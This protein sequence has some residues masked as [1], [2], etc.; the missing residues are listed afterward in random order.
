MTRANLCLLGAGRWGRRY[1]E[2]IGAMPGLQLAALASR[3]P[4]SEHL[5]GSG[6][7][8]FP[9]WRDAIA[10]PGID[11]VIIATPPALHAEMAIAT[12]ERG[13]PVLVE[14]PLTLSPDQA[15]A[16][17][18]AANRTQVAAMVGHIHLHNAGYLE[19]KRQRH[20]VGDLQQIR[21]AAGNRGPFRP[22]V[23]PLWDWAPHDLS[24]CLD[25][26]GAVPR[27]VS[28]RRSAQKWHDGGEGANYCLDLEF[29]HGVTAD[30]RVGNLMPEKTRWLELAGT[31]GTLR[32]DDVA[33]MLE[34]RNDA[35]VRLLPF[36]GEKPLARQLQMFAAAISGTVL[37][38]FG[39]AEGCAVVELLDSCQTLCDQG[40]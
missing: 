31:L 13:L 40:C 22:D 10:A 18:A 6:C 20:L 1:V 15:R 30:I 23:S 35:G 27:R 24:M 37:P 38:G 12:L 4:D 14:K 3:N 17:E 7:A 19:L 11:G 28:A 29:E 26:M 39:I 34:Y 33:S 32:L 36:A 9:N 2:T 8:V 25:L 16:I 21:S 5:A